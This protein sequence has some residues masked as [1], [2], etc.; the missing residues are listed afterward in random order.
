MASN[1]GAGSWQLTF[2]RQDAEEQEGSVPD[3]E[4]LTL[5]DYRDFSG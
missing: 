2:A 4:E 1:S 3:R 5:Q